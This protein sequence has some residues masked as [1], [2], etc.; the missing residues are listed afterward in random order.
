MYTIEKVR[1]ETFVYKDGKSITL[2]FISG[3]CSGMKNIIEESFK[4]DFYYFKHEVTEGLVQNLNQYIKNRFGLKCFMLDKNGKFIPAEIEYANYEKQ[5]NE[6]A[7][8]D[9]KVSF[10]NGGSDK[11]FI[12]S[13]FGFYSLKEIK[14]AEQEAIVHDLNKLEKS[15]NESDIKLKFVKDIF[16]G[17]DFSAK[18]ETNSGFSLS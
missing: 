1:D 5:N 17:I 15:N 12:S 13:G 3:H 2:R 10:P 14:Q 6:A 9:Y 11:V 16:K 18:K 7:R 4:K 8:V